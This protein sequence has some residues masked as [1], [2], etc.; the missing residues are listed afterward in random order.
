[1]DLDVGLRGQRRGKDLFEALR[2]SAP[3][4]T[5]AADPTETWHR[6]E[7]RSSAFE[8]AVEMPGRC[9]WIGHHVQGLGDDRGVVAIGFQVEASHRSPTTFASALLASMSTTSTAVAPNLDA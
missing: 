4:I 6:D 9:R 3:P 5:R 7:Q 2:S 1:M 8:A